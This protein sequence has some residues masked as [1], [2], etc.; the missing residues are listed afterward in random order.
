MIVC[1]DTNVLVQL[2][3][4][5]QNGRPLRS[6]LLDGNVSLVVSNEILLEYEETV[7]RLS[8][9]ARW[10]QIENFLLILYQLNSNVD[11]IQPSF[12]FQLIVADPDDNKF[13]DCAVTAQAD[14][15]ITDDRH[16]DALVGSGYRPQPITLDAFIQSY[17]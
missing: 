13:V 14:H 7:T 15:I 4:Q 10:A 3:G 8:G 2:F 9:A 12:R 5:R 17:L 11:F 6:A 1:I 16:F